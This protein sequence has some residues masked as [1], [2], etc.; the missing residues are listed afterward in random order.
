MPSGQQ[1]V[2]SPSQSVLVTPASV[3]TIPSAAPSPFSM[4]AQSSPAANGQTALPSIPAPF[5]LP[6]SLMNSDEAFTSPT[7][8]EGGPTSTNKAGTLA[9]KI[10]AA[11]QNAAGR[12]LLRK[13]SGKVLYSQAR[14]NSLGPNTRRRSDSTKADSR[15]M[16]GAVNVEVPDYELVDLEQ[17]H[18]PLAVHGLGLYDASEN[19]TAAQSPISPVEQ[20]GEA[21]TV[22]EA[23]VKGMPMLKVTKKLQQPKS[24]G[25]EIKDKKDGKQ[26]LDEEPVEAARKS[27][28]GRKHVRLFVDAGGQKISWTVNEK[29]FSSRFEEKN[30]FIDNIKELFTGEDAAAYRQQY[31]SSEE[32][33]ERW[34]TI[35]YH[36]KDDRKTI[37]LVARSK[38]ELQFFKDNVL[39]MQKHRM[40][41][42]TGLT[43]K[44][45]LLNE[46]N[47][48]FHWDRE[49]KAAKAAGSISAFE[50]GL[51]YSAIASLCD[52][53]H[54]HL[55]KKTIRERFDSADARSVGQL[56][57]GEFKMFI[58]S[59]E[60]RQ[61]LRP[62]YDKIR[63]GNPQGISP[64]QFIK[65]LEDTQGIN[66]SDTWK[67]YWK[68]RVYD[69]WVAMSV[70]MPSRIQ[71]PEST[72]TTLSF[73]SSRANSA[74]NASDVQALANAENPTGEKYM[75]FVAFASYMMSDAC[76]IYQ[77]AYR[78]PVFDRPLN[79]YYISSSH[80]TYLTGKQIFG[81]SS[82][83]PYITVLRLGCKCLEIDCWDGPDK[84]PKVTHG[85]TGTSSISFK[86]VVLTIGRYAFVH[87]TLPLILSLEV[88]CNAQ[89][90][91]RMVELLQDIL[92]PM[93]V[94][95]P[96]ERGVIALP[97][98]DD[99]RG[100]I[101]IKV[102]ASGRP[103]SEDRNAVHTPNGR[104]RT[105]S[106]PIIGPVLSTEAMQQELSPALSRMQSP[107]AFLAEFDAPPRMS[108]DTVTTTAT[109]ATTASVPASISG[110]ESD[111]LVH[112]SAAP[113]AKPTRIIDALGRLGVY[114]QG[115]TFQNFDT[116][117]AQTYNHI[118]SLNERAANDLCKNPTDKANFED[119][120][121]QY[122]ARVYPMGKRVDSSNFDP[123]IYWRRG[124]Q[125]VALNWQ[126]HDE[127]MQIY[128]A[129]FAS[130]SDHGGYVLKPDYLLN[131]RRVHGNPKNRFKLVKFKVKFSVEVISAQR[132][133]KLPKMA[134]LGGVNPFIELQMF[135]AEDKT[136]GIASG[137]VE[138]VAP[139]VLKKPHG[140]GY[141]Y[142]AMTSVVLDNG[143]NPQWNKRIELA[144]ETKYPDLVF[145]RWIVWHSP[146][147]TIPT[148]KQNCVQLATFTAKLGSLQEG[149]RHL[150]LYAHNMEE[151]IF[152]G[153]FC[154]IKKEA[155]TYAGVAE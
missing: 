128:H 132:L 142:S 9:R 65:H 146:S 122:M 95:E 30:F 109:T 143:Y 141:P 133:P 79:Q 129:M 112:T 41:L 136:K 150:P 61:D 35:I 154:K 153:L 11:S 101:L 54:I 106:S 19:S 107:P 81:E 120:N 63:D 105:M 94:T 98:P 38:E 72:S 43:G 20:Q 64:S 16:A 139:G 131:Q 32:E 144:L 99:L 10:S 3:T 68:E 114:L 91:E 87:S 34:C 14:D 111:T 2:T 90:Q 55:P 71:S 17:R 123:N 88:H 25:I 48:R 18:L 26:K 108:H 83:E 12:I 152:S 7:S 145:V 28:R 84:Q 135:S 130:P 140:I 85:R 22:P 103:I 137:T 60:E 58:L 23:L 151:F 147:A 125:M 127:Y 59:I 40:E 104:E 86:E 52:R 4:S 110:E 44:D 117:E 78:P 5:E 102:K 97:S 29:S 73:R 126:H 27:I 89:Q 124:V 56:N 113:K 155:Q 69:R 24:Q 36:L 96:L 39:T 53:L 51:N 119:H 1:L 115:H 8:K 75:D 57:Y 116:A 70:A 13:P 92:K 31:N 74:S 149:Y 66:M 134:S 138:G 76:F 100:K 118:F 46:K 21:P 80:N 50:D 6:E 45:G 82:T 47:I 33:A 49:V 62:I 77:Q 15:T 148:N 37:H 42:M 93:L 67:H 121:Q